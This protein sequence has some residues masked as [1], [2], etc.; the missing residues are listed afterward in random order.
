MLDVFTRPD[1]TYSQVKEAVKET[2][3]RGA[4]SLET[5]Q[6]MMLNGPIQGGIFLNYEHL[7]Q[8]K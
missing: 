1:M 2:V 6:G 3:K 7:V 5:A 8:I 4:P